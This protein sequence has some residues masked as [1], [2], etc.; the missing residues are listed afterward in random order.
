MPNTLADWTPYQRSEWF[1]NALSRLPPNHTHVPQYTKLLQHAEIHEALAHMFVEATRELKESTKT[2][3]R[4]LAKMAG[5]SPASV[6]NDLAGR[7][8]LFRVIQHFEN[9]GGKWELH[10]HTPTGG[11][12]IK[13]PAT[14]T[15]SS[16]T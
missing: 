7:G 10:L 11:T 14:S 6:S 3:I 4:T 8:D 13:R 9:L 12:T 15:P 16:P 1:R 2:S 5:C